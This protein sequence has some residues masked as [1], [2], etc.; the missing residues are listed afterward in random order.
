MR[1]EEIM[2][3]TRLKLLPGQR[4]TKALVQVYGDALVCVRYRYDEKSNTRI[5][6]V[7]L[8]VQTAPWKPKRP[9]ISDDAVVPVGILYNETKLKELTKKAGG[10]WDPEKRLWMIR[11]SRIKNTILQK[12]IILDALS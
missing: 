5:K 10:R 6:T 8:V 2:M 11:Y 12:H 3:T 7:E 1:Q 9:E 4:G